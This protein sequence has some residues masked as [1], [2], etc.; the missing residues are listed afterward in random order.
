MQLELTEQQLNIVIGTLIERPFKEVAEVM[1]T[2]RN[3]L[4][5]ANQKPAAS[6]VDIKDA[7]K[8]S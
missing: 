8:A 1:D 2:I 4:M 7:Q 5:A 6:V 3:Q